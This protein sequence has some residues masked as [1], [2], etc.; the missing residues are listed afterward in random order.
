M[1]LFADIPE[2]GQTPAAKAAGPDLF[3][4]LPTVAT[5]QQKPM[6]LME[7]IGDVFTG[8]SRT[9]FPDAPEFGPASMQVTPEQI[10]RGQEVDQTAVN[11]SAITSDPKAQL[12]ILQKQIPGL[13]HKLDKHGNLMLKAPGMADF[14]YLNKP[15]VSGRDLDELGTQVLATLPFLSAG[16]VGANLPTRIV[17]GG[18]AAAGAEGE[19]NLLAKAQG[20]T[21]D[22]KPGQLL[23]DVA[24]GGLLAPGVPSAIVGGAV[25]GVTQ[26]P[27]ANAVRAARD[28]E[29][30]AARRVANSYQQATYAQPGAAGTSRLRPQQIET[31]ATVQLAGRDRAEGML[32]GNAGT[33]TLLDIMGQPGQDLA[34]SAANNSSLAKQTINDVVQPR[35]ES[36]GERV[37]NFLSNLVG[38]NNAN[39]SRDA[40]RQ[41]ADQARRP[42]YER[43]FQDG[44]N[45]IQQTPFL[46]RLMA[47]PAVQDAMDLAETTIQNRAAAGRLVTSSRAPNGTHTLE[48]W[49]EVKRNLQDQFARLHDRSPSQAG[50]IAAITERL[51]AE[52]DHQVPSYMHARGVAHGI[53]RANNALDAGENFARGLVSVRDARRGLAQFTPQEQDLFRQ[54]YISKYLEKVTQTGDRRNLAALLEQSPEARQKMEIVLG[55]NGQRQLEA[56]LAVERL[57]HAAVTAVNGNSTTAKQIVELGLAGGTGALV[58]G[59]DPTNPAGWIAGILTKYGAHRVGNAVDGRVAEHVARML[60]SRDPAVMRRGAELAAASPAIMQALRRADAALS[61]PT[62]RAVRTQLAT[63]AD[64][65]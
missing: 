25:K 41:V 52:L 64:G 17:T 33:S 7:R 35:L 1:D 14:A 30:E 20:S 5:P 48:F 9:E 18:L 47:A 63:E 27:I 23:T 38:G 29:G 31:Q 44:I 16:G 26:N 6:G 21:Q 60:V 22:L 54:G 24:M 34:R 13:E 10:A 39:A 49:D 56:M 55:Q 19:K 43:A 37:V 2:V 59:F 62:G 51:V 45:G 46:Q 4:D 36:Q 57:N 61:G 28:P 50:H 12:E 42:A 58:S 15:G 40:L 3:G 53:F 11:R 8:A 32:P 65:Q